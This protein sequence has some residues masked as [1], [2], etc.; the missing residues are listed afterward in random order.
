VFKTTI[1]YTP[2]NLKMPKTLV[3]CTE[4]KSVV[5]ELQVLCAEMWGAKQVEVKTGH[6]PWMDEDA[7]ETIVGVVRE[8]AGTVQV[9]H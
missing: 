1:N 9:S 4:D 6:S 8:M 7:R 2:G 5:K 3:V